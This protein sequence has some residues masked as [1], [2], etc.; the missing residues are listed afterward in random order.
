MH[1]IWQYDS[2]TKFYLP[3]PQGHHFAANTK[4][5]V[6]G[7]ILF[8]KS[9]ISVDHIKPETVRG[10][11]WPNELIF[12]TEKKHAPAEGCN[13]YHIQVPVGG[14]LYTKKKQHIC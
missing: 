4:K 14:T 3:D 12:S 9:C 7:I 10:K 2:L 8:N 6:P 11:I 5:T 1:N 13:L